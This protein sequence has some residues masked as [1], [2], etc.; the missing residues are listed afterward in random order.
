[1]YKEK[2]SANIKT[3][4]VRAKL[5]QEQVAEKLN[6]TRTNITKYELGQL[7]PNLETLGLLAELYNVSLDWLFGIKTNKELIE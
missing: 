4:R 3:A 1:M 2:F 5:T 6:I 7:E